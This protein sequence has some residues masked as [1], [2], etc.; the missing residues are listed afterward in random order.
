MTLCWAGPLPTQ[1]W[2][3]TRLHVYEVS[4]RGFQSHF[5]LGFSVRAEPDANCDNEIRQQRVHPPRRGRAVETVTVS[6]PRERLSEF[7]ALLSQFFSVENPEGPIAATPAVAPG[8]TAGRDQ[9]RPITGR[10]AP[11]YRYLLAAPT[12]FL[13]LTFE[14][15][16]GLLGTKL[17]PSARV[18]R[19]AWA[20]SYGSLLGRVWLSA[21]WRLAAIDMR[22]EVVRFEREST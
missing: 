1:D 12:D 19:P 14:Q 15:I 21:G 3:A 6:V 16:E 22:K 7:Y 5:H 8:P 18:H 10:Y 4:T 2:A 17:P 13:E 9:E 11:F 20:N